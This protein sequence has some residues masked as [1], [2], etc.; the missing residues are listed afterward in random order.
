MLHLSSHAHWPVARSQP[1]HQNLP[2]SIPA[3]T[4]GLKGKS[5]KLN[6]L[7]FKAQLSPKKTR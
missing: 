4:Q 7:G 2:K 1:A 3:P 6:I 5:T